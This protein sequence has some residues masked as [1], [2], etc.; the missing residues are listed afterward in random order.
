METRVKFKCLAIAAATAALLNRCRQAQISDNAVRI[1]VLTDL[2][3]VYSDVSG[4]G[5]VVAT[6]MAI[7]DFV[8][9]ERPVSR[10]RWSRP[11]TRT[12][13]TLPPTRRASGSSAEKVDTASELV[14]TSVALAV[15]EDRQGEEPLALI[16]GAASTRVTNETAT[17]S[18]CTGPTT[19]MRW[20]TA[21]PRP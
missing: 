12:R 7:D 1:G 20:P 18:R 19:P 13:A 17:T 15:H 3:G 9:K 21:R 4:K 16:S 8:A 10:W 2:S 6:Q 14:T 5:T 11:T